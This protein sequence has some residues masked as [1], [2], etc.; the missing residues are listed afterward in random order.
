LKIKK[1]SKNAEKHQKT[2]KNL[3]VKIVTLN[4]LTKK[5][6]CVIYPLVSR[7]WLQMVTKWLQ[8]GYKMVTEKM[9]KN[10]EKTPKNL[11]A[12]IVT[13]NAV[14]RVIIQDIYPLIY[15]NDSKW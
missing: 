5:T 1:S 8:N 15:I 7:K 4:V 11:Y 12:K 3:P 10:A 2:P 9:P 13:L 6:I 14:K